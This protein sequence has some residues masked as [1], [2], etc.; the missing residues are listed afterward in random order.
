MDRNK[1]L[2]IVIGG[3]AA[4]GAVAFLAGNA[5]AATWHDYAGDIYAGHAYGL[6]VPPNARSYEVSLSGDENATARVA[7]YGPDGEQIGFYSL[8]NALP[9]ASVVSPAEG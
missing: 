9:S 6:V 3:I 7:A 2:A 1:L 4:L 8:S 5:Q